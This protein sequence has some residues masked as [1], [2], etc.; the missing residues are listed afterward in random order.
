MECRPTVC[1]QKKTVNYFLVQRHQTATKRANF[2][3]LRD[4]CESAYDYVFHLAWIMRILTKRFGQV[5]LW[6]NKQNS[7]TPISKILSIN[8][9][10]WT[11]KHH[12]IC[13]NCPL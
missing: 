5:T 12:I 3:D 4:N 2:G 13:S 1:S 10:H 6:H 8:L 7:Q 9:T 11:M